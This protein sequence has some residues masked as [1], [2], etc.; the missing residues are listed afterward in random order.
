MVPLPQPFFPS[1]LMFLLQP[2]SIPK[3]FPL[4]LSLCPKSPLSFLSHCHIFIFHN[5]ESSPSPSQGDVGDWTWP[6][7]H[8]LAWG[9]SMWAGFK[10]NFMWLK[11]SWAA[12]AFFWLFCIC[13]LLQVVYQ[14]FAPNADVEKVSWHHVRAKRMEK[15]QKNAQVKMG[16]LWYFFNECVTAPWYFMMHTQSEIHQHSLAI[17]KHP[18]CSWQGCLPLYSSREKPLL[19]QLLQLL[20]SDQQLT[21][22]TPIKVNLWQVPGCWLCRIGPC[23]QQLNL[24]SSSCNRTSFLALNWAHIFPPTPRG[25]KRSSAG[26]LH[27]LTEMKV[28]GRSEYWGLG[29]RIHSP[30]PS[31]WRQMASSATVHVCTKCSSKEAFVQGE[32]EAVL[33]WMYTSLYF[34]LFS[35][36]F[37]GIKHFLGQTRCREAGEENTSCRRRKTITIYVNG[38]SMPSL[39]I[40]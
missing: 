10:V 17:M 27:C 7:R 9:T 29:L 39:L 40:I 38:S 23:I 4:F 12:K 20:S 2:F 32:R 26:S 34:S 28:C 25:N 36:I 33:L 31:L 5:S 8:L 19:V 3:D 11:I 13:I 30:P 16:V 1:Q 6:C 18:C 35:Y 21:R 22:V 37:S 24:N 15:S 14:H